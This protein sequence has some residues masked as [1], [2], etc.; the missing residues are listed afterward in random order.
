MYL[1]RPITNI[2][3][4]PRVEKTSQELDAAIG[5]TWSETVK[6]LTECAPGGGLDLN[7]FN[8]ENTLPGKS[9]M[10]QDILKRVREK[11][12]ETLNDSKIS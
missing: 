6:R 5:M 1:C 11:T 9:K 12:I 7:R 8:I 2:L 10:R 3:G 4:L